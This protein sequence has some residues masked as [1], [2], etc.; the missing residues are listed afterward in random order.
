[1]AAA[2]ESSGLSSWISTVLLPIDTFAAAAKSGGGA[3]GAEPAS[4]SL[5][6][7]LLV[8]LTCVGMSLLTEF[9]SNVATVQVVLPML[10]S[11]A[12]QADLAPALL[13]IPA[14]CATSFAFMLPV[15]TPPNAIAI[16]AGAGAIGLQV[17][18]MA[19]PGVGLNCLAVFST[20][21]FSLLWGSAVFGFDVP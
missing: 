15:A 7:W 4:G 3:A 13:M 2:C 17:R 18:E 16:S 8:G 19:V 6:I 14:T 21:V 1:M 5:S 10:A 11:V 12:E 9:T 20:L